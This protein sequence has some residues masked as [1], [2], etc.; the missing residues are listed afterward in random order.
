MVV[1]D[2]SEECLSS[3]M[4]IAGIYKQSNAN[5]I[6]DVLDQIDESELI[7]VTTEISDGF[8]MDTA[9]PEPVRFCTCFAWYQSHRIGCIIEIGQSVEVQ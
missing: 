7:S 5:Q 6:D 4:T 9:S 1:N 2:S 3:T 8:E